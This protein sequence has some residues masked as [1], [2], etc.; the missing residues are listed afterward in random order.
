MSKNVKIS[1]ASK[2]ASAARL[3]K[4]LRLN[5][6]IS[7]NVSCIADDKDGVSFVD[8]EIATE[9]RKGVERREN[10]EREI[11]CQLEWEEEE[12]ERNCA[13]QNRKRHSSLVRPGLFA[14]FFAVIQ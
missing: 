14:S 5:G 11:D 13:E 3:V 6:S 8:G 12:G 4:V 9:E 2:V 1:K 7:N 10:G